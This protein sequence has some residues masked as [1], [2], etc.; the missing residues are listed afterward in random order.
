MFPGISTVLDI[1]GQDC[2]VISLFENGKIRKFEMNDRCA[3]GTG[4]FLE[5]MAATLGFSLDEL[6]DHALQSTNELK[7]NSMCTVF[8]E[9]EVISLISK[10]ADRNEIAMALHKSVANRAGSMLRRVGANGRLVFAGGVA[11]NACMV[12]L[13]KMQLQQDIFVPDNPQIVGA[14]GASLLAS[15]I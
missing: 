13:L 1:G 5:I 4:K 14:L 3:A 2:K 10:G 8:A 7:I 11:K 6:G 12:E 9:S 15:E